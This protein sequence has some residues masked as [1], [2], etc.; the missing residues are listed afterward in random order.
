[1]SVFDKNVD[2]YFSTSGYYCLNISPGEPRNKY[3]EILVLE[4]YF[5]AV[6]KPSQILKIHQQF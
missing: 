4:K 6:E 3:E 5:S 1:M 2:L